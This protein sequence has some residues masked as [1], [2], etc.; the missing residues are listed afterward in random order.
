MTL[1]LILCVYTLI[2][3]G[4]SAVQIAFLKKER[5]KKA[6]ILDEEA[7]KEAA[8][9]GIEN[10]KFKLYSQI[11]SFILY[12]LWLIFGFVWLKE[13]IIQNNSIFENTVFL[14]A[15]L[16]INMLLSLPLSIYE[17]FVKDK[18]HGFST[19]SAGL[20]IKDTLKSLILLIIFGFLLVYALLFCYEFLGKLWWLAAFGV[21]FVAILIANVIYPTLIAPMFN[22]MQ[23]LDDKALQ[24]EISGAMEKLKKT[25]QDREQLQAQ[26]S[27]L[28]KSDS[29]LKARLESVQGELESNK[30]HLE[31]LKDE[32]ERLKNE[33]RAI[34]LEKR[35]LSARLEVASVKSQI[36]EQNLKKAEAMVQVEKSEK[37][38]IQQHA[39][40]LAEGVGELA[41]QNEKLAQDVKDI[42]PFTASEIFEEARKNAVSLTNTA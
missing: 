36:Y 22:K 29:T 8:S 26:L 23:K 14:L 13:L 2:Y 21:A 18:K 41:A 6:V 35:A 3:V 40:K 7:Y 34:E 38:R 4:I 10:E 32:S 19:I 11:Y 20:F 31:K 30:A 5:A 1:V 37:Q 27:D 16:I 17:S 39:E 9:V 28:H 42:R 12:S 24:S 15:F 33:N 25:S